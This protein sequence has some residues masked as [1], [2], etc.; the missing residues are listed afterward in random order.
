MVEIQVGAVSLP[1]GAQLDASARGREQA[2]QFRP[3]SCLPRRKRGLACR[4]P[5]SFRDRALGELLARDLSCAHLGGAVVTALFPASTPLAAADLASRGAAARVVAGAGVARKAQAAPFGR[6]PSQ[7]APS[8][9]R[10]PSLSTTPSGP[11]A[12]KPGVSTRN[13]PGGLTLAESVESRVRT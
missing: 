1:P 9:L 2:S 4:G 11:P 8:L 6:S 7:A 3:K 5:P 12:A 10:Q 13:R